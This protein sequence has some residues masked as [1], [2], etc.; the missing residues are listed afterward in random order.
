MEK[1]QLSYRCSTNFQYHHKCPGWFWV[2]NITLKHQRETA[3]LKCRCWAL[4]LGPCFEPGVWH[5]HT[6][7]QC[8]HSTMSI[9]QDA[10]RLDT[11]SFTC[12]LPFW[13]CGG[14]SSHHFSHISLPL[15][16]CNSQTQ[17]GRN[18]YPDKLQRRS[19]KQVAKR[20]DN[21]KMQL[22]ICHGT[23]QL[24]CCHKLPRNVFH[25]SQH[26]DCSP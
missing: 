25:S 4:K 21:K 5:F 13:S 20:Q 19:S 2:G 14:Y 12:T 18:L 17:A 10:S 22:K 9:L 7:L 3:A 8:V 11:I 26:F 15:W 1:G 23:S 24:H 16:K 6:H